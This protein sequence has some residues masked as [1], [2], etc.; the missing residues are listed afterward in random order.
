[1]SVLTAIAEGKNMLLGMA[2]KAE[3]FIVKINTVDNKFFRV[4]D[5]LKGLEAAALLGVDIVVASITYP[6]GNIALEGITDAEIERVFGVL[7]QSGAVLFGS[8]PNTDETQSWVGLAQKQFPNLRQ[9]TVNIGAISQAVFD[10]RKAEIAAQPDVHF[11]T[12]NAVGHFC[13]INNE[14]VEEAISS[15]YG[16]YLVAGVAALYLSSIK[17]REKEAYQRRPQADFLKGMGQKFLE[18]AA[19]ATWDGT[20]PVFYKTAAVEL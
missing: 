16:A 14:Y 17:K 11:L 5:F 15:S 13:K 2:P 7:R 20:K 3:V 12:S 8:L 1:S 6:K 9:E 19:T 10:A 18:L 4:K